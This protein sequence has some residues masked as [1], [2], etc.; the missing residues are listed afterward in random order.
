MDV[1]DDIVGGRSSNPDLDISF[2]SA[3]YF[4]L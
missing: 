1:C 2:F 3:L 4:F